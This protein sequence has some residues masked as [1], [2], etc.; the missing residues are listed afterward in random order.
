VR[1]LGLVGA[2]LVAGGPAQHVRGDG[3]VDRDDRRRRVFVAGAFTVL[4][5]L[6]VGRIRSVR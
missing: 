4:G 6:S 3:R 1:D 2:W 5:A